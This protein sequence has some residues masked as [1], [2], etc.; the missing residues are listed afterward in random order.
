[1][2]RYLH[3]QL[4]APTE[5]RAWGDVRLL[6]EDRSYGMVRYEELGC[7]LQPARVIRT[8][9]D[10]F[11]AMCTVK[12]G[13]NELLVA[14]GQASVEV[15]GGERNQG[16]NG[17]FAYN[18]ATGKQEWQ[19]CRKPP[20]MENSVKARGVATDGHGRLFVCDQGN[21]CIHMF[22]ADGKYNQCLWKAD[23]ILGD[24]SK[25]QWSENTSCFY[26]TH[27]YNETVEIITLSAPF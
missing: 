2:G 27:T 1:M 16:Q 13:S 19:F 7:N 18:M 24:L 26:V 8:H 25:I 17:V 6:V 20:G 15:D 22:S 4:Q 14:A 12:D 10:E 5:L 3:L 11:S 9:S 21:T 23:D